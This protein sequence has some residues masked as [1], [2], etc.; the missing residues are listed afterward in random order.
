VKD[1]VGVIFFVVFLIAIAFLNLGVALFIYALLVVIMIHELGHL[2]VAKWFDFK[3]PQYFLGFGPTL[4]STTRGETEYGI[5]AIP[6]GGFVKILGMSPYEEIDP[7]DEPRSYPNKPRWQRAILLV[8][9]SATHWVVAFILLL[10]VAMGFGFPTATNQIGRVVPVEELG[11]ETAALQAGLREGDRIVAVGGQ[12]TT[13]WSEIV[14]YIEERGNEYGTFTIEPERGPT[15]EKRILIGEIVTKDGLPVDAA[16]PGEEV[17]VPR[18]GEKAAGFLGVSPE[19]PV[20]RTGPIEG[21]KFAGTTVGEFTVRSVTSLPD[22]FAPVFNGDLW[23]SLSEDG[24]RDAEGAVG[25]VGAGRVAGAAVEA[26]MY[27]E[28]LSFIAGLTIFIGLM[29]LLPLPPLDGGHLAV[30]AI[31]KITGKAVDVKKLIP[32]AAVV[33]AFFLVLFFAVLYLDLARPIKTPF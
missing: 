15:I 3:A 17:R 28:L 25:L 30:L 4:W 21:I 8:A 6:A 32:V 19:Q 5:K 24:E 33:I 20:Q 11:I 9:G 14:A 27:A 26:G 31:E 1:L 18:E 13:D 12:P 16:A 29:N 22:V 10:I 2:S 23:R 7:E